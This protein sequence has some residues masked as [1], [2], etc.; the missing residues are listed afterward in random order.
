VE[1]TNTRLPG[2]S[3]QSVT[4]ALRFTPAEWHHLL[5]DP[6]FLKDRY[7]NPFPPRRLMGVAVEIVPDHRFG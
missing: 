7:S 5:S 3:Y 6:R 4:Y 2:F 1:Q